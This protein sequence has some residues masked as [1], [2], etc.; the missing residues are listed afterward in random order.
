MQNTIRYALFLFIVSGL[1][2]TACSRETIV[3]E[4]VVEEMDSETEEVEVVE[5]V[6][7]EEEMVVEVN[8]GV[9][10]EMEVVEV[11]EPVEVKETDA[12]VELNDAQEE[13]SVYGDGVYA[14]NGA[15]SSPAGAETIGVSITVKD[16]MVTAV[17]L[18]SQATNATSIN[19]QKL[20]IKGISAEVVGKS[21][22]EIG[23]YSSINGSSLTPDG[24]DKALASIKAEAVL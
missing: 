18:S 1:L 7:V 22:D 9:V 20:F 11:E 19:F 17:N 6:V 2:F 4:T 8:E 13:S 12:P 3:E 10:E 21:L 16:D 14:A 15:Y 5:E 23:G 24:F